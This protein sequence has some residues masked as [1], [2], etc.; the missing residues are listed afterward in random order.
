MGLQPDFL[1][2]HRTKNGVLEVF[3]TSLSDSLLLLN[4]SPL[5]FPYLSSSVQNTF[6]WLKVVA[7]RVEI[8]SRNR[9]EA[10]G[11]A[12]NDA[13][14]KEVYLGVREEPT[15]CSSQTPECVFH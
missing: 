14:Y 6:S 12:D 10:L 5:L 11:C 4:R 15:V 8:I 7:D 9:V 1:H 3:C 2:L 13:E